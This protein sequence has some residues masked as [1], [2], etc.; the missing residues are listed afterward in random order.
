VNQFSDMTAT[1]FKHM[2][3]GY[4]KTGHAARRLA[5]P[6][7]PIVPLRAEDLPTSVDWRTKG[8][9]SPVKNQGGC[10]SCWAFAA[11]ETI[12]SHVAIAA[13]KGPA[14]VLAPQ[15]FVSCV[16]NPDKCGGTGGCEGATAEL[17]FGYVINGTGLAAE[18][19]YPYKGADTKCNTK[20]KKTAKITGFVKLPEN[21][22]LSLLTAVA[23]IGPISISVDASV[24]SSYGEGV[25]TGC[26]TSGIDIDHA[27]QLVGY[28]TDATSGLD[29]WLVRNS[30]GASWGEAGYVR[31]ARHS[32]GDKTKWCQV[33]STPGD[34]SGCAGGPTTVTVCGSCGIWYD[35]CYPTGATLI[36]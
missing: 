29:Y 12:E 4:N 20:V 30:W 5:M 17:A 32:D 3:K 23:T 35:T 33:D 24:W 16:L 21:D 14:P 28:G 31:I 8:V 2:N 26:P 6:L 10:G 27:V 25:Y 11:T 19:D 22:Y 18:A 34:G 9:M 36:A 15:N 13:G 7:S 1:Q